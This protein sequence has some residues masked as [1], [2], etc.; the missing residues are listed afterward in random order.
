MSSEEQVGLFGL[1][2]FFPEGAMTRLWKMCSEGCGMA[3]RNIEVEVVRL[4]F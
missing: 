3:G 4:H 1:F 2:F